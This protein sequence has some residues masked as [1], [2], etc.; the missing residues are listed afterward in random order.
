MRESSSD[1]N[2]LLV[3]QSLV[4]LAAQI[5]TLP[6]A[7]LLLQKFLT[8][9]PIQLRARNLL[10]SMEIILYEKTSRLSHSVIHL[11]AQTL[12]ARAVAAKTPPE[13]MA[14][15]EEA[16]AIEPF[17]LKGNLQLA[18]VAR[19]MHLFPVAAF[20]YELV[21]Q[22]APEERAHHHELGQLY[23]HT[24][25]WVEARS[26]YHEILQTDPDDLFAREGL[27]RVT[28]ELQQMPPA[29]EPAPPMES[30]APVLTETQAAEA[31]S[32]IQQLK[33]QLDRYQRPGV[34][35]GVQVQPIPQ[36]RQAQEKQSKERATVVTRLL[37]E[38]KTLNLQIARYNF[39][40]SPQDL[41]IQYQLALACE[42]LGLFSEAIAIFE[43]LREVDNYRDQAMVRLGCCFIKEALRQM[44][45]RQSE[46]TSD[47]TLQAAPESFPGEYSHPEEAN[48]F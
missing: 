48:W 26:V 7:V 5:D 34:Q 45:R 42:G 17:S 20:A 32:R 2:D 10:R 8:V 39:H 31:N 11:K 35:A 41:A 43:K 22:A 27:Q 28:Q 18:H 23:E 29:P 14:L 30:L 4:V 36:G 21:C 46:A 33:T 47:P 13:K 9:R 15:I 24:K 19:E 1:H 3:L 25:D 40:R 12:L 16:L 38:I 6:E 44:I 37:V